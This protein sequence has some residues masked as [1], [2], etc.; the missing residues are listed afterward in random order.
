LQVSGVRF[1]IDDFGTG[2]SSLSHLSRLPFDELKIDRSLLAHAHERKDDATNVAST[3]EMAHSMNLLV[4][5]E[6]LAKAECWNR[7]RKLGGDF[8]PGSFGGAPIPA[9][10]IPPCISH[11]NRL[12]QDSDS[13]QLQ[14]RALKEL[15]AT[16]E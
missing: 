1:S 15:A 9:D 13:T 7:R 11:A 5:A 3:I 2:Y 8:A 6:G 10:H 16:R 14:I 12:L 4:A